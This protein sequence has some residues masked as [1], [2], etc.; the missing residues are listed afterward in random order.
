MAVL[1]DYSQVSIAGI[2]AFQ[3]D[4]R[5]GSDEKIVNLIR[6]VILNSLLSNKAKFG[7]KYGDLIICTDGRKY[8][9]K[10]Y[11]EFYKASRKKSREDSGLNWKLI[12]DTMSQI[13]Q[14]LIEYFPYKVV[15]YERAE[16][17]DVIG[18]LTKYF[19]ENETITQGL[20]E[21]PQKILILSSD[22]DNVQLQK[23]KNVAQWSPMQKKVVKP[24]TTAH[25]ALIE[26][27][28][29]GDSG[30]GIPGILSPDNVFVTEGARQKPFR[31]V[32]LPDFYEQG[33]NA[34]KNDEERRNYQRNELLVSYDR[35]PQDVE[36]A[37]L[38][39]YKTTEIKG[40]RRK[41]MEYL[42]A[43]N[44]RN[45]MNSIEDF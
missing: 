7:S 30:D 35:I 5:T 36:Q 10:D 41:I 32:R 24:E 11:F 33:I 13:K 20:E 39:T 26:K 9:R 17:D 28:C 8:W 45:L 12:F 21:E 2:L 4:L 3:N 1:V 14:D 25:N 38:H 40:N 15:G 27:I 29:L 23:Y 34:C 37:I 18:V 42:T 19:Q 44:C 43:H 31:K 16:A 6:H 22:R